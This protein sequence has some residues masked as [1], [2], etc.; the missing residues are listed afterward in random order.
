[1][2]FGVEKCVFIPRWD[3]FWR[4]HSDLIN[5]LVS[6]STTE[7]STLTRERT[8]N[9]R[10]INY[11]W[12]STFSDSLFFFSLYLSL[13]FP[14]VG[15]ISITKQ[16][17]FVESLR[18]NLR[19]HCDKNIFKSKQEKFLWRSVIT[20]VTRI[21]IFKVLRDSKVFVKEFLIK[22]RSLNTREYSPR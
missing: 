1:M 21:S 10:S 14:F 2:F 19:H 15:N 8:K 20:S 9:Q 3:R 7:I 18:L 22:M 16:K 4:E 12:K 13:C 11:G 6:K 17:Y 5:F